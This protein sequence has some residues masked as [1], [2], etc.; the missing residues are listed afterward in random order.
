MTMINVQQSN[1]GQ[2]NYYLAYGNRSNTKGCDAVFFN[3]ANRSRFSK[4]LPSYRY[5]HKHT[6]DERFP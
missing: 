2:T 6:D 5:I 1:L 4:G 3:D